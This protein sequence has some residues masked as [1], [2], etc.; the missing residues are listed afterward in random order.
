MRIGVI[1]IGTNSVR[2]LVTEAAGNSLQVIGSGLISTRLGVGV[3][4]S[5]LLSIQAMDR[6]TAALLQF[7]TDAAYYKADRV[8][9]VATSAV[10]DA[11]NRVDFLNRVQA[12]TGLAVQVLDGA[13]EARMS[14]LGVVRGSDIPLDKALVI[15]VGGGSTEFIWRSGTGDIICRSS[16][17]GAVRMTEGGHDRKAII[18]I[19]APVFAE[20]AAVNLRSLVGVGG[21]VTTLAA[22]AQ[23][24][25]PYDREKVHG[26]YLSKEIVTDIMMDLTVK[27]PAARRQIIGLQPARADIILAGVQ[28]VNVI[29]EELDLPGIMVS[30]TDIMYGVTYDLLEK[31]YG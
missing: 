19:L 18:S 26:F 6:T 3:A 4:V 5:R 12:A 11:A 13:A 23:V 8:M 17:V 30:E 9:A 21:T 25:E 24:L 15:D 14:Y 2:L 16:Q 20:I 28:I 1:D 27:T 31:I 10:R 29:L 7:M 22:I